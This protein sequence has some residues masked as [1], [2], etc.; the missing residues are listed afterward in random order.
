MSVTSIACGGA[1]TRADQFDAQHFASRLAD[2]TPHFGSR[3]PP[4]KKI[5][6][7]A[8]GWLT[9]VDTML[10]QLDVFEGFHQDVKAGVRTRFCWAWAATAFA[11]MSARHLWH[12]ARLS[13]S[14]MF[15]IPR[16]RRVCGS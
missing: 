4:I 11:R 2:V 1:A 12:P 16:Y 3:I 9:V 8:L 6:Q 10:K 7:N 5:I 15:W 13:W 14:C